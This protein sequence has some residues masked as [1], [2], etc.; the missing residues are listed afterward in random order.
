MLGIDIDVAIF[1]AYLLLNLGVGLKYGRNVKT[2]SDYA[3]GGRNFSTGALVATI[4]GTWASGSGFFITLSKVYSD[5]IY[6]IIA[7]SFLV[8]PLFFMAFVF[9]PRMGEFLGKISM[10]EAMG[11]FYGKHVRMIV[12]MAGISGSLGIVAMQFKVVGNIFH[13]F[14]G[15]YD[16]MAVISA[17]AVVTIYSAFGGIRSITFTD[18]LQCITFGVAIPLIGILIWSQLHHEPG[19]FDLG[20]ALQNPQFS[21][22]AAF[23]F[24]NVKFWEM[25]PL[26]LFF[27]VPAINPTDSQRVIMGSNI[28]QVKRA[29]VISAVIVLC[30]KLVTAWIP[31]LLYNVDPTLEQN[32][33][34]PYIVNN[35]TY[36]GL[37]GLAI[38]AVVALAMSTADAFMNVSSVMF[39][40]DLCKPLNIAIKNELFVSRAFTVFL[41][42]VAI[43]LAI[44]NN[45]LLSVVL[46]AHSF[47][48][49]I[50]T[51]PLIMTIM[52]FRSSTLSVLIGMGAG[53]AVVILWKFLDIK[54]DCIVVAIAINFLF[55]VGSHYILRQPGGWV[56]IKDKT[57]LDQEKQERRL[58]KNKIKRQIYNFSVRSFIKNLAPKNELMYSGFGIYCIICTF[59]TMYSTQGEMVKADGRLVVY[60][61]QIMLVTGTL[62]ASY[63]VWPPSIKKEIIVQIWWPF[64]VFYVLGFFSAFFVLISHF[65]V[66]QFGVFT[67]N[68][69]IAFIILGWRA[70]FVVVALGFYIAN[71]VYQYYTDAALIQTNIVT[72]EFILYLFLLLGAAVVI[73]FKPKEEHAVFAEEKIH[74]LEDESKFHKDEILSLQDMKNEF[75]RNIEHESR[76]PITGITSMGQVLYE[77]YDKLTE[78]QR[79]MAAREIAD[80]SE[81]LN[82]WATNLSDLS[83]LAADGNALLEKESVN[84]SDLVEERLAV[85]KKL[86]LAREEKETRSFILSQDPSI[87][88]S[89]DRYYISRVIDNL[90][91]NAM[92]YSKDGKIELTLRSLLPQDNDNY[93]IEFSISDEGIGIPTKDLYNIFGVLTVSAKTKTPSGGRGVGLT[94]CKKIIELHRGQVFAESNGVKGSTFRFKI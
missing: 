3:L 77:N 55:L 79:K 58:W 11:E 63:P 29:F 50:V 19:G 88:V 22:S 85:C 13:N 76:T 8:A 32:Q 41:G 6:Y 87:M 62:M 67:T 40:H 37:K 45:D 72:T 94:L 65:G 21:L 61:Y 42:G 12:A 4:V 52:G 91:I 14:L 48:M 35:Y 75:I 71:L 51:A 20:V 26:L 84:L 82:S 92:Q 57:F 93:S 9:A 53:L 28:R 27:L 66:L 60:C 64:A 89:C 74:Y 10:A 17:G 78:A 43:V 44:L 90:I 49:P 18:V 70:G 47:H 86:Y 36:V 1:L 31:F 56:G 80:S 23:D 16:T 15:I 59:V 39:A 5:G 33:L 30:I 46:S 83:R 2:I 81:R 24:G 38:I 73:F 68:A 54:L 25:I 69:I 7:S 34:L